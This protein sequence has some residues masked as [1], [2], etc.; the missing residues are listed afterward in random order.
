MYEE[1]RPCVCRC[2]SYRTEQRVCS[3]KKTLAIVLA[4]GAYCRYRDTNGVP[5]KSGIDFSRQKG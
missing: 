5:S 4:L 2:L 3:K 1:L